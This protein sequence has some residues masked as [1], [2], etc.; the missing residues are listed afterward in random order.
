MV[1]EHPN[2]FNTQ[3]P[4][5]LFGCKALLICQICAILHIPIFIFIHE[6]L[7]ML[8]IFDRFSLPPESKVDQFNKAVVE[9]IAEDIQPLS[10]VENREFRKLINLLNSRYMLPSRKLIGTTLIPNLY[11]STRKM[12]ETILSHTKYVSITSDNWTSLNTVS[13]ITVT[14]HFFDID[15]NLKHMF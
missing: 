1:F 3:N 6:K 10:I 12:I 15:F 11:E 8:I 7:I 14:V 4:K 5:K 13:F 2:V 9:M